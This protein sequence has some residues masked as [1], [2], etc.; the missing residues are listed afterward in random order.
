M[1][2]LG[3]SSRSFNGSL[4][5]AQPRSLS[6]LKQL[7]LLPW[8]VSPHRLD[9]FFGDHVDIHC[10]IADSHY[11]LRLGLAGVVARE[12]A[13]KRRVRRLFNGVSVIVLE[14]EVGDASGQVLN[15]SKGEQI[16]IGSQLFPLLFI[17]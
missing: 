15:H 17:S 2:H 11:V 10:K 3:E 4:L 1:L 5:P 7:V 6:V 16:W 12:A 9:A 14:S 13:R 8:E